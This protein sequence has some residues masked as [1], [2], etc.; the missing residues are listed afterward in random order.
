MLSEYDLTAILHLLP[1]QL[2]FM[3]AVVAPH[4]ASAVA[5]FKVRHFSAVKGLKVIEP[6]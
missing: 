2:M 5:T 1:L 4:S 6:K 3:L